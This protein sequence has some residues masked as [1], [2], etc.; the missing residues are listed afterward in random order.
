M[1]ACLP[2]VPKNLLRDGSDHHSSG[3]VSKQINILTLL[4]FFLYKQKVTKGELSY[5]V[6]NM[7]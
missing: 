2:W 6:C 4:N 5:F 1:N 3:I 7:F